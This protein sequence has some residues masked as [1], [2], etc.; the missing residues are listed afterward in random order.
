MSDFK[1]TTALV[2]G[3]ANSLGAGIVRAFFAAGAS[4]AIVDIDAAAGDALAAALQG[5]RSADQRA[6]FYRTDVTDDGQ[7]QAMLQALCADLGALDAVVNNAC[8][9]ADA[10]MASTRAQWMHSWNVNVISGAI[11][12][13]LARPLLRQSANGCVVNLAS[14]AGK[15]A[16]RGRALY[17]ACKAAL[18]QLTRSEAIELAQDGIRVNAISPAWTWSAAM[19]R[20]VRGDKA[21]ANSVAGRLHPLGRV[22]E[23]DDVANAVL[24]LCSPAA[25]FVTGIDLPVDGGYSILGPDQ[26]LAP[27]HWFDSARAR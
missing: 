25:R 12:T 11:L 20:Q 27:S 19:E 15:I 7:L 2:T 14:V 16:Q 17:P 26:G 13:Q 9:Y 23:I 6:V 22:G 18:L 3:G 8:T 1:G 21:F 5:V 10:G 24:Y 4:V